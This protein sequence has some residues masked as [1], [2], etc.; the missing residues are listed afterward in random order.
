MADQSFPFQLKRAQLESAITSLQLVDN[1]GVVVGTEA[2]EI[3]FL[4]LATFQCRLLKTCHTDAVNDI[5]FPEWVVV[6]WASILP[7]SN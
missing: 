6:E 3:Y 7:K 5:A 1:S 2:C 4:D